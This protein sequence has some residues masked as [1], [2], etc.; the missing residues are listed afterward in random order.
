MKCAVETGSGAIIYSYIPI[1]I[2]ICSS[3]QKLIEGIHRHTA[4]RTHKPTFVFLSKE[5]RLKITSDVT[6]IDTFQIW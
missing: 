4:W 1:F 3:T 2:K 6:D 5:S